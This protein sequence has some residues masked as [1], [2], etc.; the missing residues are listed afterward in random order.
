MARAMA[1][2]SALWSRAAAMEVD[3]DNDEGDAA[4]SGIDESR[5]RK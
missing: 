1:A 4:A 2:L 3:G 5:M